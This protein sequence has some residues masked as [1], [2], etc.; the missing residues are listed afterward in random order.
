MRNTTTTKRGSTFSAGKRIG[1]GNQPLNPKRKI[2]FKL[3]ALVVLFCACGILLLQNLES[4]TQRISRPVTKVKIENQWQ[5]ISENEVQSLIGSYMGSG[6]FDFDVQGVRQ[7]LENH[8]WV[9]QAA[10]KKIWPDSVGL[11]LTEEVAIAHWGDGQLLNQYGET[12]EPTMTDHLVSLPRLSGPDATQ[13]KVM[14]QYRAVNQLFFQAGLRVTS[15]NLSQRGNWVLELNDRIQITAGRE[16]VMSR[17]NRFLEFYSQQPES[18]FTNIVKVDLRYDNGI[19]M[20]S[21]H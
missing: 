11:Q 21:D 13:V 6:F 10:V 16:A 5:S 15:L 20:K 17:L 7:E 12:F 1:V 2:R 8:P 14:E 18:A 4:V 3:G 9:R 19:A